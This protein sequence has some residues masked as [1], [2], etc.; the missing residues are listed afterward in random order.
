MS[1][2][3]LLTSLVVLHA[4][5]LLSGTAAA[6]SMSSTRPPAAAPASGVHLLVA[7]QVVAPQPVT[8]PLPTARVAAPVR[9]VSPRPAPRALPRRT[10][11]PVVHRAA[12]PVLSPEALMLQAVARIPGYQAGDA[13]WVLM[14][15]LGHWG[16]TDLGSG[17]VYISPNVPADR[18]YDVV[19]HEWSHVLS[20]QVYGGNVDA[21]LAALDSYYGGTDVVGAERAADCMARLLGAQWTH[22]TPCTD[23]HWRDGARELLAHQQL[24]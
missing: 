13:T 6:V 23:P 15:G 19:V 14:P 11:A 9:R 17:I 2:R 21:A 7:A 20:M 8:L 12:A 3:F 18:M 4:L 10:A 24:S 1:K 22:Y 16:L 5:T